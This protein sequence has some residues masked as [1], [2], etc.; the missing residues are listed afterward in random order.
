M[1]C[2]RTS[3][4]RSR[5]RESTQPYEYDGKATSSQGLLWPQ[6]DTLHSAKARWGPCPR[7]VNGR[8]VTCYGHPLRGLKGSL[9]LMGQGEPLGRTRQPRS[10][11]LDGG[12]NTNQ[13]CWVLDGG[14]S[15]L[16][17]RLLDQTVHMKG[18]YSQPD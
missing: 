8:A 2:F 6:T 3:V 1:P 7:S 11:P 17:E 13:H 18:P 4:V 10:K 15:N 16:I 14:L 5:Q 9:S 12:K